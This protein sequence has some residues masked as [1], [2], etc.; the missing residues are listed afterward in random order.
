MTLIRSIEPLVLVEEREFFMKAAAPDTTTA[1]AA[2]IKVKA[3]EKKGALEA[4]VVEKVEA[5][6]INSIWLQN[7]SERSS[8]NGLVSSAHRI[9]ISERDTALNRFISDLQHYV[10]INTKYFDK[11]LSEENSWSN[12][13]NRQVNIIVNLKL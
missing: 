6:F 3:P 2:S 9:A 7:I 10:D 1:S 4:I 5:S 11:L 8:V 12:R 13:W